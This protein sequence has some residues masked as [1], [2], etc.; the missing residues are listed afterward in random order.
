MKKFI[1]KYK[2]IITVNKLLS[3]WGG[4]LSGKKQ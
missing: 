3:A 4:F 1:K 2:E